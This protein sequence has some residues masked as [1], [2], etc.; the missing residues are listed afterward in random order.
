MSYKSDSR[1]FVKALRAAF[2]LYPAGSV[3]A[4][5]SL[6]MLSVRQSLASLYMT[7]PSELDRR[8]AGLCA[9]VQRHADESGEIQVKIFLPRKRLYHLLGDQALQFDSHEKCRRLLLPLFES[10]EL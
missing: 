2:R 10:G 3:L 6:T 1:A 5:W 8:A 9:S 7:T 4:G